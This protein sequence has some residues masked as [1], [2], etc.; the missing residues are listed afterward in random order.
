MDVKRDLLETN[1][2]AAYARSIG[3]TVPKNHVFICHVG[4]GDGP[5]EGDRLT[6][7]TD[8]HYLDRRDGQIILVLRSMVMADRL[9]ALGVEGVEGYPYIVLGPDTVAGLDLSRSPVLT[10]DIRLGPE[11]DGA[12][13]VSEKEEDTSEKTAATEP[14]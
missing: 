1:L 9:T 6:I 10:I 8:Q 11:R 12:V 4:H 14:A 3:V 5:L 2:L 13:E 7:C